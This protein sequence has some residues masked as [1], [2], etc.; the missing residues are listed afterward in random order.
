VYD[1][2]P[3]G[4]VGS[5]KS[6]HFNY[7]PKETTHQTFIKGNFDND[8]LAKLTEKGVIPGDDQFFIRTCTVQYT[9]LEHNASDISTTFLSS[10]FFPEM[11]DQLLLN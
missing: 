5:G 3:E 11:D 2:T 10:S 9:L 6:A 4:S 1:F 7:L 8:A